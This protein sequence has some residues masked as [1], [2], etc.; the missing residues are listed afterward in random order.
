[1]TGPRLLTLFLR[2]GTGAYA[3]A[4]SRLAALFARQLPEVSRDVVVVDNLLPP[5]VAETSP[6]RVVI[7]GD[8]SVS[9]F[10]AIDAAIAHVGTAIWRYDLVNIVTAAF[11]QLY[12]AYLERFTPP[13]V[14]VVAGARAC[15]GQIDCY[16][17]EIGVLSYRSQHWLRT[18]FVMLAPRE[19]MLLGSTVSARHR[20]PW[21]SGR[22]DAPFA[23]D[24]PLSENYRTYI[25]DWLGGEDIGQGVRWHKTLSLDGEGL[26]VFE[27]KALAILNEHLFGIRLRAAGCRTIDVTWL[28]SILASGRAPEWDTPWWQQ[29]AERDRHAHHVRLPWGAPRG[30]DSDASVATGTASRTRS[31]R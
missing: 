20:W 13:V 28:S 24:A 21:F 23:D 9:E 15:L 16:N 25:L 26:A 12:V 4:E 14:A 5:G 22:P 8:N 3:D 31:P 30:G 6:G 27:R 1:M 10:S 29:L 7:G 11:E 18:S 2:T 19:L 17:E